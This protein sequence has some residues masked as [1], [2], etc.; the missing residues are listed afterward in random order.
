MQIYCYV[1][2]VSI[3]FHFWFTYVE[4]GI[5]LLLSDAAMSSASVGRMASGWIDPSFDFLSSA[6]PSKASAIPSKK[7]LSEKLHRGKKRPLES[8][9]DAPSCRPSTDGDLWCNTYAP[10]TQTELAV[11]KKKVEEVVFHL[12]AIL[13]GK[14]RTPVVLLTGPC[15]AGK[16]A[17]VRVLA[18]EM[19]LDLQEWINPVQHDAVSMEDYRHE[20]SLFG[21]VASKSQSQMFRDFLL[22]ANKYACVTADQQLKRKA[23]LVEDFPNA[24]LRDPGVFKDIVR[25]YCQKARQC[26]LVF[27][28]SDSQGSESCERKLFPRDFQ[29]EL[30]MVVVS[31][32][33]ITVT[34]ISKILT[35]IASVEAKKNSKLGVNKETITEL[36]ERNAGDIRAAINALQFMNGKGRPQSKAKATL[37]TKKLTKQASKSTKAARSGAKA[38]IGDKDSSLF[39]F[40]ALGKVLYCKREEEVSPPFLPDH[41][42]HMQRPLPLEIPE[43]VVHRSH[44]SSELFTAFLHQNYLHFYYNVEDLVLATEYL[45]DA[46]YV[47]NDW[48]SRGT[49]SEYS[50]SVATRGLMLSNG[51]HGGEKPS[52]GGW[53]PLHKPEIFA[54]LQ[55]SQGNALAARQLFKTHCQEPRELQTQTIPY[56]G[57]MRTPLPSVQQRSLVRDLVCFYSNSHIRR[58]L[59]KLDE[60]E[61][62]ELGAQEEEVMLPEAAPLTQD[63]EQEEECVIEDFED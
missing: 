42:S 41:L 26:P 62:A 28:V 36:A 48:V 5:F 34:N 51:I 29:M 57:M 31:F 32:N 10:S 11:H 12:N 22:R 46:D 52:S 27:I 15:G 43:E 13:S 18:K 8:T 23:I 3:S 38:D 54:I 16:T 55:K 53:K 63:R 7:S 30:N 19:G 9:H 44:M 35:K 2:L 45:S 50:C 61:I 25:S 58:N 24:F 14:C 1:L 40:R 47:S 60:K 17:T 49:L 20:V 6:A 37:R 39:L 59:E 33:P 4:D 21:S 56:L